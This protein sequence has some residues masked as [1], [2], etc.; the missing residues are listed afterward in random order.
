MKEC[1]KEFL[2][3]LGINIGGRL[4]ELLGGLI[5]S[6]IGMFLYW[7][8]QQGVYS[9]L[10]ELKEML[11]NYPLVGADGPQYCSDKNLGLS[12]EKAEEQGER[13]R[14]RGFWFSPL[15]PA[16]RSPAVLTENFVLTEQY[17]DGPPFWTQLFTHPWVVPI[18]FF[19]GAVI[20]GTIGVLIVKKLKQN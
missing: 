15:H 18:M 6:G 16:P 9:Y 1:I 13:S 20:G 3:E 17:W 4:G 2:E 12:D 10:R 5:G 14:E 11:K 7:L 8:G 19:L